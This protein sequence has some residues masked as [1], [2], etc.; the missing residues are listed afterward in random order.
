MS[1]TE[2]I[3][4]IK[5]LSKSFPGVMA[6][7]SVSFDI[8]KGEIHSI[9]GE[10][11]AGKS[12]LTKVV[13]GI[14]P[15]D[16]GE[17]VYDGRSVEYKSIYNS[18]E[19]RIYLVFQ[20]L[21][22][23]TN[24]TVAENIFLGKLKLRFDP[25]SGLV[26]KRELYRVAQEH[27]DALGIKGLE[28]HA[29][30]G[31]LDVAQ[32]QLVEIA[33]ALV[34]KPKLLVLDE[35]TSALTEDEVK[36][37]FVLMRSLRDEGVT[38]VL[39][40][41]I[42]EDVYTISDRI[43]VLR[44]GSHVDTKPKAEF[45]VDS[46]VKMMVGRE[47]R[48]IKIGELE[49][50][51]RLLEVEHLNSRKLR[52]ASLYVRKGE[53]LGLM[54]LQGS[55]NAELLRCIYGKERYE[56]SLSIEGATTTVR[57]S[58]EAIENGIVY[59]PADRKTE[60]IL[61]TLDLGFNLSFLSLRYLNRFGIVDRGGVYSQAATVAKRLNLKYSSLHQDPFTLSGGN[62]QKVVIGKSLSIDP[63]IVLMDDPT[64]GVDI[65]AK[66]EIYKIMLNMA[67]EGKGIL[68]LSTE[69]PELL[70]LCHRIVVFFN[71][72]I[73]G[74]YSKMAATEEKLIALACGLG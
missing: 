33:K 28:V 18:I 52:D 13:A 9:V 32:Q 23:C 12:T 38:I 59:I 44:D 40:S 17:I 2:T 46:I 37:L 51:D 67:S 16:E 69:L 35:P 5:N 6:L 66:N 54:G 53:I 31:T 57:S 49:T 30:V 73:V 39:I 34:M 55:G 63:R 61:D 65:G 43:T 72:R 50:E 64:R 62:Q 60:G 11:G 41:H 10:N 8:V 15:R 45:D 56:G 26:N 14:H 1:A 48:H 7:D 42:I 68:F 20:E 24:L 3:L 29:R 25:K 36:N 27:L 22:L 71:G 58:T 47:I 19:D 70:S 74:E 21:S 4:Q